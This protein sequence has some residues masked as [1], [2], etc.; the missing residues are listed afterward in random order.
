MIERFDKDKYIYCVMENRA[1]DTLLDLIK[2]NLFTINDDF[3][4][5]R[6]FNTL[7]F[8]DVFAI[9][10]YQAFKDVDYIPH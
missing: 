10:Q 9:Y 8:S 7:I 3:E 6:K 2:A 5:D 4:Q 1:K